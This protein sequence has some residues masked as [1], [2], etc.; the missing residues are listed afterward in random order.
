MI[1][2]IKYQEV[3]II[4]SLQTRQASGHLTSDLQDFHT[5][6]QVF[7]LFPC[8]FNILINLHY[9]PISINQTDN[10]N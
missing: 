2:I 5:L 3:M 6:N 8:S 7:S 1:L 9:K 4:F 10:N